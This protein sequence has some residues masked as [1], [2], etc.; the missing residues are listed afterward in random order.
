MCI[1]LAA[2]S[3]LIASAVTSLGFRAAFPSLCVA[4][5]ASFFWGLTATVFFAVSV[6]CSAAV[7]SL[8]FAA[9]FCSE[10]EFAPVPL[11]RRVLLRELLSP[12]RRRGL[13]RW[14]RHGPQLSPAP[15]PTAA[16]DEAFC[17]P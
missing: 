4:V 12:N 2:A 14:R 15:V 11:R 9:A 6:S 16:G 17:G 7:S 13:G 3:F 1:A 5:A 8:G 10:G